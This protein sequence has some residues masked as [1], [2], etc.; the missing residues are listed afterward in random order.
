MRVSSS[1]KPFVCLLVI[2]IVSI[3]FSRLIYLS[4]PGR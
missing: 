2:F 4:V 1:A 3:V